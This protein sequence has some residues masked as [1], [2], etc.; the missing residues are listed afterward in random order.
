MIRVVIVEDIANIREGI[1]SLLNG[2]DGFSCAGEFESYEKMLPEI[3]KI[4]PDV[5]LSDV[6]LPGMSGID[7]IKELKKILPD[8]KI[9]ML[10]IHEDNERIFKALLAGA[11]G[12]LTKQTPPVKLL[13]SIREANEGGSPMNS[14]IAAKVLELMR[15]LDK[16]DTKEDEVKL[17]SRE[18][19]ILNFLS[20]GKPY[21]KI[22][23]EIN[24]SY[25]TVRYHIRNI[26]DKL[27]A[28][29]Q[30]EA[31]SIASKKGLI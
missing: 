28:G 4:N 16:N 20:Q 1:V 9:I 30:A 2:T 19:E 21:K 7:G 6:G 18:Y 29:S 13:E 5:V 27:H 24:I 10:T 23:D 17:S 25:H 26:Y 11:C 8:V 31:I 14:H 3:E 12:Y 15:E 22:A